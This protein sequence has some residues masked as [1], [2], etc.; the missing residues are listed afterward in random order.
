MQGLSCLQRGRLPPGTTRAGP[1]GAA[2]ATEP[3]F[4]EQLTLEFHIHSLR[5]GFRKH[6]SVGFGCESQTVY[7]P[8][9]LVGCTGYHRSGLSDA[10]EQRCYQVLGWGPGG[11]G[12]TGHPQHSKCKSPE[13][14]PGDLPVPQGIP[15][16][17]TALPKHRQKA[18]L[19]ADTP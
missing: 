1:R 13:Q 3:G 19:S 6:T 15:N 9:S 11:W 7:L 12:E 14:D 18:L 2:F 4:H 10:G 17:H 8:F 5:L 16:R